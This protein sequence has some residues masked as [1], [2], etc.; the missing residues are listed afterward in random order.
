MML[1]SFFPHNFIFCFLIESGIMK[2]KNFKL[3]ILNLII[4]F[5][6]I[7]SG[8]IT[9]QEKS[10]QSFNPT[11]GNTYHLSNISIVDGD[12]FQAENEYSKE[13]T[14]R[15]LGIDTPELNPDDNIVYEYGSI[16]NLSC[17]SQFATNAKDKLSSI[18]LSD[19]CYV[20]FDINSGIKDQ[21]DRYLC[22]VFNETMYD[23]G[24]IL[25]ESGLARVYTFESFDKKNDY[26]QIEKSVIDNQTG[27]WGCE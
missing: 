27:L 16:T 26:L 11:F 5:F 1:D 6:I 21:Y 25:L 14:I 12:T 17:L 2:S 24:K 13:I 8:C 7:W 15:I 3:I 19:F 22:Y 18:L 10:E 20:K 9:T 23:V 4:V